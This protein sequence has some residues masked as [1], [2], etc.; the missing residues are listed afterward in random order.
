MSK[1]LWV[2][3]F[4]KQTTADQQTMAL[5]AIEHL[6]EIGEV[7]FRVDDSVNIDGT[8]IPDDEVVDECLYWVTCGEDLRAPF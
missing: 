1:P 3:W 4:N 5:A 6:I 7:A 2:Q 8:P